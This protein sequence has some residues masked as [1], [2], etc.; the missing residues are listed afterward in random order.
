M[1]HCSN[2]ILEENVKCLSSHVFGEA[3]AQTVMIRKIE[4]MTDFS[5][6]NQPKP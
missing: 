5:W 1:A 4:S 6:P 3:T 2:E